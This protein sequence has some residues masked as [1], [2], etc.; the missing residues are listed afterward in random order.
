MTRRFVDAVRGRGAELA[1]LFLMAECAAGTAAVLSRAGRQADAPVLTAT[2]AG[3]LPTLTLAAAITL[4]A[5]AAGVAAGRFA[6]GPGRL[7]DGALLFGVE[8]AAALPAT[9]LL[10]LAASGTGGRF[11]VALAVLAAIESIWIARLVRGEL[12]SLDDEQRIDLAAPGHRPAPRLGVRRA[13]MAPLP[14]AGALV[15]AEVCGVDATLSMS[16]LGHLLDA[17][18]W[19][20]ALC[21]A[22]IAFRPAHLAPVALIVL[23]SAAVYAVLRGLAERVAPRLRAP[24]RIAKGSPWP[25]SP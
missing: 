23:S 19:G 17:P 7:Y 14:L 15:F 9:A 12:L 2:W 6:A 24:R 1:G 13:V 8:L 20:Q 25:S 11:A 10:P 18:T 22:V 16:G 3:T 4:A 21:S 5:L